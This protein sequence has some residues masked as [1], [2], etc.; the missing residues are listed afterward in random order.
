MDIETKIKERGNVFAWKRRKTD[1][2]KENKL[3]LFIHRSVSKRKDIRSS[4]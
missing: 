2:G 3:N 1:F 4:R